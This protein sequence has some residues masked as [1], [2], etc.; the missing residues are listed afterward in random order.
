MRSEVSE[1]LNEDQRAS[2]AQLLSAGRVCQEGV[3]RGLGGVGRRGTLLGTEISERKCHPL[4]DESGTCCLCRLRGKGQKQ[5]VVKGE[6]EWWWG[7]R[8][9]V[10]IPSRT[11]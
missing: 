10:Y 6:Q 7:E 5:G 8:H 2:Q 11:H 1:T 9:R 3:P 4:S